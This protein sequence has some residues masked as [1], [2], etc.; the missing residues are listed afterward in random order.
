LFW[1]F[2][3]GIFSLRSE[4]GI[5]YFPLFFF[6]L[7]ALFHYYHI[8]FPWGFSYAALTTAMA[9]MMHSMLFFWHRY[10]LPAVILGRVGPE[11]IPEGYGGQ[12]MAVST[13]VSAPS[14]SPR[15]S[16]PSVQLDSGRNTPDNDERSITSTH[17][18]SHQP[19]QQHDRVA[20][21]RTHSFNTLASGRMSRNSSSNGMYNRGDDDDEGSYMYFMGGEVVIPRQQHYTNASNTNMVEQNINNNNRYR[22]TSPYSTG[23]DDLPPPSNP[24]SRIGSTASSLAA[25]ADVTVTPE[26]ATTM[27]GVGTSESL[28]CRRERFVNELPPVVASAVSADEDSDRI[29][30][31]GQCLSNNS[32]PPG[33][34]TSALLHEGQLQQHHTHDDDIYL[35]DNDASALQAIL[36]VME[37]DEEDLT[38]SSHLEDHLEGDVVTSTTLPHA[39]FR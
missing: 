29:T 27:T 28:W 2:S 23:S 14:S 1:Y 7:F 15:S 39:I 20:V 8:W 12:R 10:E 18:Q 13:V 24:V 38:S 34:A 11:H 5:Q 17:P 19:L 25:V 3:G 9:F 6:L 31:S 16:P 32:E 26:A 4:Q 33:P 35:G 30:S 21:G 37:E 22:S 36:N